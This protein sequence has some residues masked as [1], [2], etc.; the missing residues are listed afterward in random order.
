MIRTELTMIPLHWGW[1]N[2][3]KNFCHSLSAA[4]LLCVFSVATQGHAHAQAA[5]NPPAVAPQDF[6]VPS[7]QE[8]DLLR[9]DLRSKKKQII[10]ANMKLSDAEAEKFWP[11]YD[12]YTADLVKVN[13]T[14]YGLIKQYLQTYTTMTDAEAEDYIKKWTNL[15]LSVTQLRQKYIPTFR[16]VLSAKNTLL[17]FQMDR[18]V[19]LMIDLQLASQIPLIEP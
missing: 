11:V 16:K 3:M 13:D 17:F 18:R 8:I 12:Q 15:D 14:K 6:Q 10:A 9:K 4:F 19:G 1:E 5:A 7:D 2:P